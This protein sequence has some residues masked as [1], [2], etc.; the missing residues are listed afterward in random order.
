M[1]KKLSF[2]FVKEFINKESLLISTHY[3]NTNEKLTIKC[4]KCNKICEQR[5]SNYQRGSRCKSYAMTK[6]GKKG[7]GI[8]YGT[9]IFIKDTIK[10]CIQCN[11]EF[12]P[13]ISKQKLCSKHCVFDY[14]QTDIYR[15]NG[16][17]NGS[18]GGIISAEK[19]QRRSKNEITFANLCIEYFGKNNIQCN[20]RI[21]KDKNNNFW[22]CDVF[23]KNLKIAVLWDGYYYHYGKNVSDKQKARDIIKRKIILNNKCTYYTIVDMGKADKNFV[24]EQ[25]NLFIH[26]QKFKE[27]VENLNLN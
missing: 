7:L 15:N 4:L 8:R 18:K 20:E 21:F 2:E 11:V 25:F 12:T 24:Q 19:Q 10:I 1:P 5:F 22:D 6:N 16:K 17:I 13:K 14:T 26:K 9:T 23:I 3:T 27:S